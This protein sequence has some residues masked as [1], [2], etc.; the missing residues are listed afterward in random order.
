MK[1]ET[2]YQELTQSTEMLGAL[3][4]GISQEEAQAKP[5]A[6]KWSMLEVVCHLYDEEREDFREHLDFILHRQYEEWHP[7]SPFTWVKLRKYNQQNFVSMKKKFF[8]EREKSLA[9][10]KS[11]KKSD[12]NTKYKSKWGTMTAGDMLS[13]WVAHDNLHIRQLVELRRF[14]IEKV[15]TPYKIRYAG[16]W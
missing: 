6:G 2:L 11:I 9:W 13:S 10:L 16:E 8:K 5:S 1:F 3:L 12:W 15:T 4:A 14:R 7:I